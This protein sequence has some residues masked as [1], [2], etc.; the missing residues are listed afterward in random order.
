MTPRF[1][2]LA[3]ASTVNAYL[4][5]S[6]FAQDTCSALNRWEVAR[7]MTSSAQYLLGSH[8]ISLLLSEN[9]AEHLETAFMNCWYASPNS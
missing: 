7:N 2:F 3:L 1:L 6:Q 9:C 5:A 4:Q 8:E